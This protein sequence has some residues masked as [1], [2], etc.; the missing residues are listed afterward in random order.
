M[1]YIKAEYATTERGELRIPEVQVSPGD[2]DFEGKLRVAVHDDEDGEMVVEVMLRRA[3]ARELW[4]A[5]GRWL[6]SE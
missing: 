2:L 4:A 3:E 5:V 6:D 1:D